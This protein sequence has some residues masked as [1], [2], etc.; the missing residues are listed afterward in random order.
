[1]IEAPRRLL[2]RRPYLRY[3][4]LLGLTLCA[5]ALMTHTLNAL[6][7]PKLVLKLHSS[8]ER[9]MEEALH[10][11]IL[12]PE[13]LAPSKPEE[14]SL[15]D[16]CRD[17]VNRT[18]LVCEAKGAREAETKQKSAASRG[19]SVNKDAVLEEER[20]ERRRAED[21]DGERDR[22]GEAGEDSLHSDDTQG[23]GGEGGGSQGGGSSGRKKVKQMEKSGKGG[24]GV[25]ENVGR[26][27]EMKEM[28]HGE[29][30][31]R[32]AGGIGR[33]EGQGGGGESSHGRDSIR[34]QK[35]VKEMGHPDENP[36]GGGEGRGERESPQTPQTGGSGRKKKIKEVGHVQEVWADRRRAWHD[37]RE[38]RRV[39]HLL[40]VNPQYRRNVDLMNVNIPPRL[41]KF[42]NPCFFSNPH[43]TTHCRAGAFKVWAQFSKERNQDTPDKR[44]HRLSCL[45]Y[46]IIAGLP[47]CGATDLLNVLG[48][49][50]RDVKVPLPLQS[51][52][53]ESARFEEPCG[54]VNTYLDYYRHTSQLI[55]TSSAVN[56]LHRLV[57]GE[58]A[59]DILWDNHVWP[60]LPGNERQLEPRYTNADYLHH[61]DPDVKVII[62]VRDPTERLYAEYFK[63]SVKLDFKPSAEDF[64][65]RVMKRLDV[66]RTCLRSEPM[67]TCVYDGVQEAANKAV[68]IRVGMYHVMLQDWLRVFPRD[69]VHVINYET[70]CKDT[71]TE[72]S[73]LI[74]FLK[75]TRL[76]ETEINKM[77][78]LARD[79]QKNRDSQAD[80][81]MGETREVLDNFYRPLNR[82]LATLLE[83]ETFLWGEVNR[84]N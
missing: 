44:Q 76:T 82:F 18:C 49:H 24:G 17:L 2:P 22:D 34:T 29:S 57:S 27:K 1:M 67:R 81:M 59:E 33:R 64:N 58:V 70:F 62:I 52:W 23:R 31:G 48:R 20:A 41:A 6:T 15:E 83:D 30:V 36:G 55:N 61:L 37:D 25:E 38:M 80:E 3:A 66:L 56:G 21:E 84:L 42:K 79:T 12:V 14:P 47:Q 4:L 28:G 46:F 7:S 63:D 40:F 71:K 68:R 11:I 75:I 73:K 16:Q 26:P 9:F 60:V 51:K 35:E 8:E 43:E 65:T 50:D 39:R 45:P 54:S 74:K 5:C 72:L 69:Q 13:K 19:N 78:S 10:E 77:L 32:G 53:L